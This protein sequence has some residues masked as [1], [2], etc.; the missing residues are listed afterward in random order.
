MPLA[1]DE[2]TV[3][4]FFEQCWFLENRVPTINQTIKETGLAN[5]T[6]R[7][8]L[9]SAGFQEACENRGINVPL[10]G[11]LLNPL[12]LALAN[13]LLDFGDLATPGQKLKR[14][15]I[16]PRQYSAWLKQKA[17]KDYLSKRSEELFSDA[18]PEAHAA[19]TR[20]IQNG[21]LASIKLFY[22]ISGRWSSKTA[23]EVNIE[24][25]MMKILDILYRHIPDPEVL[26]A[27]A[28][29][30]GQISG[31]QVPSAQTPSP[32]GELS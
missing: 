12:Q 10:E 22:E 16:S 14:L 5:D 4:T 18:M 11:K 17:F 2:L 15:G 30:L 1:H 20:N 25:L 9:A 3:L 13:T 31:A 28:E 21:D 7:K 6:V 26:K 27:V 23:G 19:L 32:V 8:V 29:E 24:F